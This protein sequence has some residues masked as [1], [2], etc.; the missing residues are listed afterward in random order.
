MQNPTTLFFYYLPS[1]KDT[2]TTSLGKVKKYDFYKNVMR[3]KTHNY[4]DIPR[5]FDLKW[6]NTPQYSLGKGKDVSKKPE[7]NVVKATPGVGTYN[8]GKNL[9]I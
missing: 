9:G 1:V 8:I 6:R 3:N 5:E 7:F 2:F 4:Y